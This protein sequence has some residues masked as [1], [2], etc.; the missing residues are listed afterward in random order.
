MKVSRKAVVRCI[1]A[2]HKTEH[3][4]P[5][6]YSW[7]SRSLGNHMKVIRRK[8]MGR[9]KKVSHKLE[10]HTMVM[11]KSSLGY[12]SY[13]VLDK[14]AMDRNN[15]CLGWGI[16]SQVLHNL[17]MDMDSLVSHRMV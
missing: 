13:L 17:G 14:K 5:V 16:C 8:V 12:S 7:V 11:G 6:N 10:I 2:C 15:L 1:Q 9:Y 4:K 3:Y